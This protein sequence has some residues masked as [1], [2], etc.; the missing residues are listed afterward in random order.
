[1]NKLI[2]FYEPIIDRKEVLEKLMAYSP[3][4]D[5]TLKDIN[6]RKDVESIVPFYDDLNE[7]IQKQFP[8]DIVIFQYDL[9]KNNVPL[10]KG[11]L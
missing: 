6:L 4:Q 9:L 8:R 11:L 3:G 2:G 10:D 7:D 5:I 1:L